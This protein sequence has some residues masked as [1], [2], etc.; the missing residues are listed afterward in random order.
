MNKIWALVKL[1]RPLNQ[2]Q[3]S[4]AVLVTAT[5]F[6]TFPPLGNILIGILIV[7]VYNGAAN[8][9]ND[10]C[11]YEIDRINRPE[12]PLPAGM[13]SRKSALIWAILLFAAGS[14]LGLLYGDPQLLLIMMVALILL[15]T[16]SL[17]FKHWP[18]VGNVVV[19]LILGMAFLFSATLFGDWTKGLP[20]ALLAFGFN[21]IREIVKDMQDVAGDVAAGARTLPIKYGLKGA[22]NVVVVATALLIVSTLLPY[23]LNVYGKYYLG[24]VIFLV[25]L[26]LIYVMMAIWR[27][28]S[29]RKCALLARILKGDVFFGLLAIYLG[30]F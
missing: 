21:F 5:L 3:G 9:L 22:R 20:P 17:W 18:L 8:A 30:K 4:I 24:V 23:Q 26:P 28:Y 14:I 2:F 13:I 12:R 29:S 19:A 25:D 27:D 1:M 7:V 10:Y 16:Y 6:E 11:D 15:V